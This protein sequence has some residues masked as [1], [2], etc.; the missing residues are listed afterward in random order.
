MRKLLSLTVLLSSISFCIHGQNSWQDMMHDRNANFFDIVAD[1]EIYHDSV[2]EGLTEIPKG[3]GIKQFRRWEYYWGQRVDENGNFP[4]PGNT[5]LE[6]YR[7][8]N[9]NTNRAYVTGTGTWEIVGPVPSPANGTGQ[10]NGN[11][12]VN[13]VAFHPT[14]AN[15]LFV[16]APSGGFWKSTDNGSS[17]TEY[18]DGLTRLGVSSIVVHPTTPNTMYI[19]TGDRDGGDAPGYG[20]WRT[21]D[22]GVTWSPRN[23][24]MGNRT[25]YEILMHPSD[26]NILIASTS[27]SRIYRSTNGGA[28]WTYVSVGTNCKD[29]AFHPTNPNIVY[30]AGG[31][32]VRS[33]DN[34]V[35]FTTITSGID[36]ASGRMAIG[37]SPDEPNWVYLLGGDG[38]GLIEIVRSTDSGLNFSVR[39]T[40]PNILGWNSNGGDTGS[41]YWYDLVMAVNPNDAD[42]IYTGGVNIWKSTNGGTTMTLSGHWTGSGGAD[43]VHADH[44]ALEF[45]PH[46]NTLYNGNDGG[47]YY[48]TDNG[49][50]WNDITSGL[51]I[52]QVYKIGV[53]QTVEELAING[54]QDNGTSVS[55]GTSF[56]TEIGGDGMECLIDPTDANYMYGSLYYGAIR[57]SSN[58]GVSF[59]NIAGGISEQG[60]WVTPFTLDPGNENRMYAGFDN[61]WR[62]DDVKA[63]TVS[64]T[65]ISSFGGTNNCVDVAVAPS[66]TN[67]VYVSRSASSGRFYRTANAQSGSPTWTNLHSNLPFSSTP[68][69]IEIDPLDENHLFIALGSDIYESTDGGLNWSDFSG[70]L[71]NI[72]L[73]TIVIDQNSP[74]EA[75]YV[76]MDVGVY[77]RDNNMSDWE[78]YRTGL[79]NIEVTELNIYYNTTDCSSML[80]A[81]TYA[82]GLWKSDLK[83]PGTVAPIACFESDVQVGCTATPITFT[84]LS[85]YGPTG[86]TW[87]FSPNTVTFVGGTNA[88]SQN[89]EVEFNATG[90]YS[91]TL[92]ATNANGN[93]VETKTDYI[94]I[95]NSVL[96]APT[97][98]APA[99]LAT[100]VAVPASFSWTAVTG[101]SITY[102]IDI[103]TDA[104]FT[105][106][107]DA[108]TGLT[109]T[110]YSSS[111]LASN[112]TYYWRVKAF[113]NCAESPF[114]TA[115]SFTTGNCTAEVS[116]DLPVTIPTTVATVTSTLNV[117]AAG[118]ITSLSVASLDISHTWIN[119]LEVTLM[120]P[121]GTTVSLV[122]QICGSENDIIVTLEDGASTAIGTDCPPTVGNSYQPNQALSG[123]NGETAAGTWTLTVTDHVNQDGGTIN[124][125]TL[126]ICTNV[127]SCTDAG[128][129]TLSLDAN[130]VCPGGSTNLNVS[131]SLNDATAWEVYTGPNGTGTHIGSVTGASIAV[132]AT[133][134][135]T[136][137]VRGEGG[138]TNPGPEAAITLDGVDNTDPTAV[139]QNLTV[140]LD[141]SGNATITAA[142]V[143][144]GSSDN[145]GTTILSI[146]TSS[147]DC[148]DIGTNTV[149]LTVNDGNGNSSTCNSTVTV[150]DSTSPAAVCQ[151]LT[152]YLDGSGNATITAA[153][154]DNGSSD[155]CGTTNLSIST[156]SFNCSNL[157]ANTVTLTVDDGNGNSSTCNATVTVAD[158]TSPSALC[159]NLT[160]YLDGSG[161]ATITAADVDNG[162]S[163][164]C[165]TT[166][167]SI[168]TSSF[169]CSDLG[170]NTV[171]LTVNDGNGNSSTCNSTVTIADTTSPA[172]V[173]QN[174]TVYLDG[175]GN[176]T[177]TAA[178]VDNGSSDNCGTANLSINTSSFD[179][180]D[181]GANTVTLTVDDGNGNS[182]TC[183][184]TV[185]VADTTA[186]NA[187]CQNLTVYLD[188]SGNA[189]ITAADVD[190]GSTDNCGTTNLSINTSSFNC[191]NIGANTVTLTVND[192]NGN[193]STC[194]S[195]VTV[196]DSTSPAAVCQNLTVYLDGSGNATIT[197]ADVDNGSSDNCGT[198]NLSINTSAFDCSDLGANTVTLTVN[199]GNGNSSTCTSTV[200]IADT[201]SPAAV[202][203]NISINLDGT[204][205]ATITAADV[206]GGSSDNCGSV[207]LSVSPSS[208]TTANVGANTVT[209][210]VT[211]GNGNSSTCTATVT[212]NDADAP[213]AQCQNL[214]VYLDGSGNATITAADVDNGSS[215]PAGIASLSVSPSSF[216][217]SDLGAN[218]VT[219]TVTDNNSNSATC[220]ATVTVADTTS[221]AAVCQNISINLD[222]TGNATITAADVD[223]GS[224]DNCGSVNLSVSP[225]S[226]TTANVGANTVTLTVTDG[227]GNSSTCTATV[228]VN[229]A[230][231]PDAQCQN[232]TVYLDG[233][234]NATITAAD[235][236]NG[237]SDPAG[238]ASLS[239]APSS[240]NCSDIGAN[241]VTLT[242]TDNNSNSAT[243]TATVTVADT[244]SP[245]AMCQNLTVYLDGSGNATITAA[246]VDN[247]SSDNCGTANLSINTSSFDC[248]DIGPNTV[249]LTVNDG[250]GNSST[251]T[252]TVTVNATL[253]DAAGAIIGSTDVCAGTTQTYVV[254]GISNATSYAWSLPAGWTG[255][256]TSNTITVTVG[257]ASGIVSV[258]GV[259]ACGS[260][261]ASSLAVSVNDIPTASFTFTTA[262]L[263]ANFTDAST[264]SPTNWSWDL[265][266]GAS[267]IAQNPA[268]AYTVGG[269]YVVCLT[270]TNSCGS[271]APACQNV[272]VAGVGT[273]IWTGNTS[274]DWNTPTNWSP[275][276]I[277]NGDD[278]IIPNVANDPVI[279]A[280]ITGSV[281]NIDITIATPV[282]IAAGGELQI[283]GDLTWNG[284]NNF[285]GEGT[286]TFNGSSPQQ[287]S[288]TVGF[289]HLNV[290]NTLALNNGGSVYGGLV[291]DGANLS[292]NNQLTIRSNA[293][294]TGWI[295]P[296]LNGGGIIGDVTVQRYVQQAGFHHFGSPINTPLMQTELSEMGLS[297]PNGGQIIPTATCSPNVD[298]SSPYGKVFEWNQGNTFSTACFYWG[299]NVRSSGPMTNARGYAGIFNPNA[300]L[301]IN[302]TVNSGT[303]TN[304]GLLN[305][306]GTGNGFH[307]ASNPYPSPMIWVS[308][309][310]FDGAAYFWQNSGPYSGTYQAFLSG[311]GHQVASMQ[312]FFT[313]VSGGPANFT[314]T[315]AQR[316]SGD[317]AFFRQASPLTE[318][319]EITVTGNGFADKTDLVFHPLASDR[320]ESELD[321]LKVPGNAD[322]PTIY[323]RNLDDL[324]S[325]NSI[326]PVKKE[327]Y[328]VLGFNCGENG[329]GVFD[330]GF[331]VR[332]ENPPIVFIE[333][334]LT[335]RSQQIHD[336]SSFQFSAEHGQDNERF[337]LHFFPAGSSVQDSELI[338]YQGNGALNISGPEDINGSIL[339]VYDLLGQL[340]HTQQITSNR[341]E[342][343]NQHWTTGAYLIRVTGTV[344]TTE[345]IR[346]E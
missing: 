79:P 55:E 328:I 96:T 227:N 28:S 7:Y 62:T 344:N 281:N 131:G 89:P 43:D 148:S 217:C 340:I 45:S 91:V 179:C 313:R 32:F 316:I 264:N 20:V 199:D 223:G 232:L 279:S 106:I 335:G 29:I 154:V 293:A 48:S 77:Y 224:S 268:H 214:T 23:S 238:I 289:H 111:S 102:D 301:T 149:T 235:V 195:T 92:T 60:G 177:I 341:T 186:P 188:A 14:D 216:N 255:T 196:A 84:D 165:G 169:D 231:A 200:T 252:S 204:G 36:P 95:I 317:P 80:Y 167:L 251:C 53:A 318:N 137:Y 321:A 263:T 323:T 76:G 336:E 338:I 13:C 114:T 94:S 40:T 128:T 262:G 339:Q 180:S 6:A 143:D 26:P 230:D 326:A 130:P 189:T 269:T 2:M 278:V 16:G 175:S 309:A 258:E 41:Q 187:V 121:G 284:T 178:D 271:S 116:L 140:Y 319:I 194:N 190:G 127:V 52:A 308:P 185:T 145:C 8:E 19:A 176:A 277:P 115:F 164:N 286:V 280:G 25:V 155:N 253:P 12:R 245:S 233:S 290:D 124:G 139:C 259:N 275:N 291:I 104:G 86:W 327:K 135:V 9:D 330:F 191:S 90:L 71:P 283:A 107:V 108:Q 213:D 64:W 266:D 205:N 123:F 129:P 220:T 141:G 112:T 197:A 236:D 75:M 162:S 332:T 172:A 151:N 211:D 110:T 65:Q 304:P 73:N 296:Y 93:D 160:V 163:D 337:L 270:A 241:T 153:D 97:L 201:T 30:G 61:V 157:G 287:V 146:N 239:V 168:N 54:Y 229:D 5:L 298:P 198:T 225:S 10:P 312:G 242:V 273:F 74:V 82:Q 226:F 42:E 47:V 222:G 81:G 78:Q 305:S 156:S 248:S 315:D 166:N 24:G 170:A 208:F 3:S 44:H 295:M 302:G 324:L 218:T 68:K 134:S 133:G 210:T 209:L 288:G 39:T 70:T 138:C 240:F 254:P 18:S 173:C 132:S 11:G 207:N 265:G 1:F 322:Q 50:V 125:W 272:T 87:S 249:T 159:Q 63:G 192:G 66:N 202:C 311:A 120:S 184:S 307:L 58:Y 306:G 88:N 342:V 343:P 292:T 83:D 299:W 181:I 105:S 297:G 35:S 98:T 174:L 33:T 122:D 183:N 244:T 310:G 56:R 144:N 215:D 103:A 331:K 100:G 34:G 37:V 38:D 142:D 113:D 276:G 85:S 206:D 234:G 147:F 158:S 219:L 49:V 212:V 171:T 67:V 203:Q 345:K 117:A 256:S 314:T 303:I 243:C 250:N 57:R 334:L 182:S 274:T 152:V 101:T 246:D 261:T 109:T 21:T 329:N 193:S 126:G 46:N 72:S 27:S 4:A 22:G 247:G 300:T 260:G 119:D 51:A 150:A 294:G 161:N 221:P 228:T 31:S 237:S 285:Q 99:D 59:G 267:S 15:T 257:T 325:I 320:W 282:T 333:D 17:W 136:Y 69:D 118:T 346:V